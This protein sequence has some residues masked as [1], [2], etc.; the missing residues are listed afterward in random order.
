MCGCRA[1]NMRGCPAPST[2]GAC[3]IGGPDVLS[4]VVDALIVAM[5]NVVSV[6]LR[7]SSCSTASCSQAIPLLHVLFLAIKQA[8]KKLVW[9]PRHLVTK[10]S[11]SDGEPTMEGPGRIIFVFHLFFTTYFLPP[12]PAP[13]GAHPSDSI[14]SGSSEIATRA[15]NSV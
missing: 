3:R 12:S 1:Q 9:W 5:L 10:N 4:P 14:F 7:S 8:K 2:D 13:H 6:R 11:N 15:A